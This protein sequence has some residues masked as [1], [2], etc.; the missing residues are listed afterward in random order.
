MLRVMGADAVGMSTVAEAIVARHAG[1]KV[2]G[3][4]CI[5][6]LAAGMLDQALSHDDVKHAAAL[7]SDA[8]IKLLRGTCARLA[9]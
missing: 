9:A 3:I 4:S 1:V 2:A 6:N 8:F 5:S 7:A